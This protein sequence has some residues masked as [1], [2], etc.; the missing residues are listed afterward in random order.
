MFKIEYEKL[1]ENIPLILCY[2]ET[3]TKKCIA[4]NEDTIRD[5]VVKDG[6]IDID[7]SFHAITQSW[8]TISLQ[9]ETKKFISF[10]M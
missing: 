2:I 9:H 6:R 8:K 10:N 7:E 3:F 1:L 4:I 5:S